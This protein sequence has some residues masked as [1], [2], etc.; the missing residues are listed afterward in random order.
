M[1]PCGEFLLKEEFQ[2]Y[3]ILEV[4]PAEAYAANSVWINDTVITPLGFPKS[5][6]LIEAA[7]YKVIEI[8]VCEFQKID[9][10]L[11]CLSLRF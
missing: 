2:Q 11:S 4:D 1:L 5:K 10:G 9:G 8:D 3:N 7:G 6:A